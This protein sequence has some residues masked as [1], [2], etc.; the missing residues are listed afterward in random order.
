MVKIRSQ[1]AKECGAFL[2]QSFRGII[3]QNM[4]NIVRI[5]AY[6]SDTL[7][8]RQGQNVVVFQQGNALCRHIV[9]D[10]FTVSVRTK[11]I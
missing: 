8:L 5:F 10:F 4:V 7:I 1:S 11:P 3:S 2:R 9:G 6:D